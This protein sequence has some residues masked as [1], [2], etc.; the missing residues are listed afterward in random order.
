TPAVTLTGTVSDAL[1]GIASVTCNGQAASVSGSTF[2]CALSLS[3]GSNTLLVQATDLAGNASTASVQV[4]LATGPLVVA[5]TAP[6]NLSRVRT[7]W[8][9]VMGTVDDATATVH[10]NGVLASVSAGT[11]TATGVPL[12]E[13]ANTLTATATDPVG[14]V[15]TAS[16]QVTLDT[17]SPVVAIT[18]PANLSLATTPSVMVT[19]TVDDATA[20][21]RV[22]GVVASVTAGSPAQFMATVTLEGAPNPLPVPATGAVGNAGTASAQVTLDTRAPVVTIA[23]PATGSRVA[24]SPVTVTG[25]VDDATATVRVNG[26]PAI[27]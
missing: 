6:A 9:T 2:H 10:V 25:T 13:G 4:A 11:F 16:V 26:V 7:R 23:A 3:A 15:G 8:V 5:I 18:A 27:V 24:T 21:V 12:H 19:G 22:N 20:T 17:T 1:S 14:N